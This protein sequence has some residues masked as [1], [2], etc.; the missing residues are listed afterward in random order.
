[1]KNH[2]VFELQVLYKEIDLLNEEFPEIRHLFGIENVIGRKRNLKKDYENVIDLLNSRS[3]PGTFN[4]YP[5]ENGG[6]CHPFCFGI[7]TKKFGHNRELNKNRTG[8]KG[9]IKELV[10][11]WIS[12][13]NIN[14]TTI[15]HTFDWDEEDFIKDWEAIINS[16][17]NKGK[18]IKIYLISEREGNATLKYPI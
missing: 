12:C 7:A 9:L 8:F 1:M 13:G 4:F 3:G 15:I 18:I 14:Q 6:S 10:A 5:S 17:K 2:E 11:Y 16:Y